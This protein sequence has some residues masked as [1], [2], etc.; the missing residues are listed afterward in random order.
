MNTTNYSTTINERKTKK[1]T[2]LV[3][4]PLTIFSVLTG[5]V[6][7]PVVVRLHYA[8]EQSTL[9]PG[10]DGARDEGRRRRRWQPAK[11]SVT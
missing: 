8:V 5:L 4:I 2:M 11:Q 7:L 6:A 10:R 1:H 9:V 3:E